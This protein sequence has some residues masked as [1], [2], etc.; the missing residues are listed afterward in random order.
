MHDKLITIIILNNKKL[1]LP[2]L[3]SVTWKRVHSLY[4]NS[5]LEDLTRGIRQ[6]KEEEDKQERK[7]S[8][9]IICK[10]CDSVQERDPKL[11]IFVLTRTFNINVKS[12]I[13]EHACQIPE[14]ILK[15]LVNLTTHHLSYIDITYQV[16]GVSPQFLVY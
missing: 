6:E 12:G 7:E 16:E 5:M 11:F 10:W 1:E 9:Y 3:K 13:K 8:K 15:I 4:C 2:P 14:F